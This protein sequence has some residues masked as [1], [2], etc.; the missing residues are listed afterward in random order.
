MKKTLIL[1]CFVASAALIATPQAHALNAEALSVLLPTTAAQSVS[2]D[3]VSQGAEKFITGLTTEGISF[4][5]DANL[6]D[7]KRKAAFK[8]LLNSKFD[9]NT[10]ARFS[11]G[12]YWRSAS[13]AQRDEYLK[14]FKKMI[15]DV[16]SQ[17][18]GDYQGQSI[19]VTGSRKEGERDVLVHSLLTQESGPD[20]K[21][22]WR[23]RKRDGRY[24]VIDVM[25][26]GVSMAVTQRS[27]F[28][29]VIQRGGGNIE[30]LLEHLRSS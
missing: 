12:R 2:T 15:V 17:R 1:T 19:D 23:V 29:S 22:D 27:D 6:S 18:F 9:M 30:A 28:S 3:S 10:I 8:K 11:L 4:L 14:S 26:E 16:Y 25:V 13:K 20:V 7:A 24:K 21:I 5:A